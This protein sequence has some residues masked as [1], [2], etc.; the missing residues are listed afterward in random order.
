MSLDKF[1][2]EKELILKSEY[3]LLNVVGLTGYSN[4]NN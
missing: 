2:P 4:I 1:L 3:V